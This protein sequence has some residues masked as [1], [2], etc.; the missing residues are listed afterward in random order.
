MQM[1]GS[2]DR[3]LKSL[4]DVGRAV[5]TQ[6]A[7]I[8]G[9]P[10]P[11]ADAEP[12][13]LFAAITQ[14][15]RLIVESRANEQR[16]WARRQSTEPSV[17]AL[18]TAP[19][20]AGPATDPGA[21][22]AL[23]DL[24]DRLRVITAGGAAA[25]QQDEV[26]PW[27]LERLADAVSRFGIAEFDDTGLSDP[28]RHQVVGRVPT[29]DAALEGHIARSVRPGLT[30]SGEMLRPQQVLVYAEGEADA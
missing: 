5:A 26:L 20:D 16:E 10:A 6:A 14:S 1:P 19:S 11:Y 3:R 17:S 28:V 12:E 22:L 13:D 8:A 7:A 25:P 18:A 30:V 23:A 21:L 9:A 27:L 15:L 4:R 24:L 29:T 2:S